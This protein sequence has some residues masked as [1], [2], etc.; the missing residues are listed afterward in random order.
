MPINV[1]AIEKGYAIE[2]FRSYGQITYRV[3]TRRELMRWLKALR[4]K[5]ARR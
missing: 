5:A 4:R 1:Y 3:K 2:V